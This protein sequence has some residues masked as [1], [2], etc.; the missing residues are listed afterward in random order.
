MFYVFK[1]AQNQFSETNSAKTRNRTPSY[2]REAG[3]NGRITEGESPAQHNVRCAVVLIFL[4]H[5]II[6]DIPC[7]AMGEFVGMIH[8]M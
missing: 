6:S 2:K 1:N 8:D 3:Y 4:P 7:L 5:S